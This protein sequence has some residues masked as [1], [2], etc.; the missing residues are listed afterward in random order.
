ML[1]KKL[2]RKRATLQDIYRLYQVANRMPK[3]ISVLQEL[4]CVTI[5]D[6][7]CQPMQDALAVSVNDIHS[8]YFQ[9]YFELFFFCIS[10]NWQT[11]K[12]WLRR[13]SM[14]RRL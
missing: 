13:L 6:V 1:S 8:N 4:D 5:N 9:F 10:R 12:I 7:L 14:L 3:I 11:T 2:L